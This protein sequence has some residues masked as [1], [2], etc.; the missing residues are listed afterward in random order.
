MNWKQYRTT[1]EQHAIKTDDMAT[2][3]AYFMATHMPFSHLEVYYGGKTELTPVQMSED[4]V[5]DKLID[6]PQNEHRVIIVRGGNGTGKSHLIRYL[7]AKFEKSSAV[8]YNPDKE[9]LVFLRRLNNSVRGVFKQLVDQKVI[10]NPEVEKKIIKFID[11]SES[12]DESS[13]KT[14]IHYKYVAEVK[15]DTSNSVY[16]ARIC[17]NI[18][19]YLCDSRVIERLMREGGAIAR[20]YNL[21]TAPSNQVLKN[22]RVFS[23][24]DFLDD[25]GKTKIIREVHRRGDPDASDFANTLSDDPTSE[26]DRLVDYL[27]SFTHKVVQSCAD[28]SSENTKSVF[29]QLRKDLKRQGKNLTLFIE[30]FTGF[31]GIDSELI[32]VL[33]TEHGGDYSDLCRVTAII[34]I[35]NDYFDQF[36][37]NFKDRVTHQISVTDQSFSSKEFL[38]QMAGRYLN[39]IYCA[40][41]QIAKWEKEGAELDVMPVSDFN[42]PCK[43]ETILIGGKTATLY[44]FNSNA[45]KAL[46]D[47]LT[48]KSPRT[49]LK[50]VVRAQLK[51]YFDGKIYG[52]GW[53]F[54]INPKGLQMEKLEHGSSIDR[55]ESISKLDRQRIKAALAIWGD[56]TATRCDNPGS[57][58]IIGGIDKRFFE[59]IG[60]GFYEG[61]GSVVNPGP[62]EGNPSIEDETKNPKVDKELQELER[63]R[64]DINKWFSED[65]KLQYHSDYRKMLQAFICGDKKACGAINWQDTGVPAYVALE[66]LNDIGVF[67]IE[68]QD[69][70]TGSDKA[71]VTMDRSADSRDALIALIESK[72]HDGWAFES[73]AYYQQRIITWLERNR[74]SIISKVM[75]YGKDGQGLPITDW[76]LALQYLKALIMG[77]EIDVSSPEK[78]VESLLVPFEKDDTIKRETKEWN[79]LIQFVLQN[80]AVFDGSLVLIQKSAATTMGAIQYSKETSERKFYRGE[81][82]ITAAER[83]INVNWDIEQSLPDSIPNNHLLYNPAALLKKLYPRIRE[84]M[85]AEKAKIDSIEKKLADYIGEMDQGSILKALSSVQSLFVAFNANGVLGSSD[86]RKKYEEPPVNIANNLLQVIGKLQ[87]AGEL[88]AT[89]QLLVY[90]S[91][92]ISILANYLRDFQEIARIAEQERMKAE[93]EIARTAVPQGLEEIVEAACRSTEELCDKVSIMEVYDNDA[94]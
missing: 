2:E 47:S 73:S 85:N 58:V 80:S 45:L 91:N 9:Q 94:D 71:L 29:E 22:T 53:K 62:R 33:S 10:K 87:K 18:S 48:T 50:D 67:Y 65:A 4:D 40:P 19:Q 44:P 17:A 24:E 46:F 13:F 34:G 68:G 89:E 57:P 78:A 42:P 61:I 92:G 59:D 28:I 32:T 5:F 6:N 12:K 66:R 56:G 11:S 64:N 27:N 1:M 74:E 15:N 49:F 70:N 20:C 55:I 30:D 79:D 72:Y 25:Q 3:D 88:T 54:P 93:T 77:K 41:E 52:E 84:V 39:A 76:C 23:R 8:V 35:T 38:V 82:L 60:L 63:K 21:I 69:V 81:E 43:W 26:I 31:T 37:D 14:E 51:E 16:K 75:A 83:L 36:R 86:L 7:K 90:S